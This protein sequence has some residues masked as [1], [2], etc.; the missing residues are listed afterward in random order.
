M[1]MKEEM[2]KVVWSWSCWG[3][4]IVGKIFD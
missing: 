3:T 4:K 1:P 2:K